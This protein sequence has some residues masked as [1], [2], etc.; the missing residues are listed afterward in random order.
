MRYAVIGTD[1]VVV[2][3]IEAT[4]DFLDITGQVGVALED[5]SVCQIGDY[6]FPSENGGTFERPKMRP[7]ELEAAKAVAVAD[8]DALVASQMV[9]LDEV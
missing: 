1:G 7:E 4:Q 9:G 2:N 6:L 8:L 5:T 3:L